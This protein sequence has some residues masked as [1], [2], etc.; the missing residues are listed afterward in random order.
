[1]E[2]QRLKRVPQQAEPRQHFQFNNIN[3]ARGNVQLRT[4]SNA[5][6]FLN[7]NMLFFSTATCCFSQQLRAIF[8]I[9]NVLFFSTSMGCFSQHELAVFSTRTCCFSQHQRLFFLTGTCSSACSNAAFF[10]KGLFFL[11]S[12][13]LFFSTATCSK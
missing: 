6:F 11:N 10:F 1:M 5:A 7:I 9:S 13:V 8:L 12:Y 2:M 3:P 4:G